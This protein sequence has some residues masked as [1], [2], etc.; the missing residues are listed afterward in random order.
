M[1]HYLQQVQV[2]CLNQKDQLEVRI[3][4]V[5]IDKNKIARRTEFS[6]KI[7]KDLPPN[8]EII[9]AKG[10]VIAPGIIDTGTRLN[11]TLPA[12]LQQLEEKTFKAGVTH[13]SVLPSSHYR[14]DTTMAVTSLKRSVEHLNL[15]FHIIANATLSP[16]AQSGEK[17]SDV[18]SLIDAGIDGLICDPFPESPALLLSLIRYLRG[19]ARSTRKI[20]LWINP[21]HQS[22]MQGLIHEGK[23]SGLLGLAGIPVISET[24]PILTM[25]ALQ[26][27]CGD[28]INL[29]FTAFSSLGSIQHWGQF[30]PSRRPSWAVPIMNLSYDEHALMEKAGK[31]NPRF[32]VLPPLRSTGDRQALIQAVFNPN[33]RAIIHSQTMT[34]PHEMPLNPFGDSP[35]VGGDVS[36]LLSDTAHVAHV[37]KINLTDWLAPLTLHPAM[38]LGLMDHSRLMVGSIANLCLFRMDL[39]HPQ[40]AEVTMTFSQGQLVYRSIGC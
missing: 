8:T 18:A 38:C 39:N 24:L 17:M 3:Q 23:V 32:K 15:N 40:S 13:V 12:T 27:E 30:P 33:S 28:H 25:L 4:D 6:E 16:H 35:F 20:T 10:W 5:L 21:M 26:S 22:F 29:H 34:A 9:N 19:F 7:P 11:N 31:F 14:L 36:C 2:V 1:S 37:H